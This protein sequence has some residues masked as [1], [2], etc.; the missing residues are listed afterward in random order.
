[1]KLITMKYVLTAALLF[2]TESVAAIAA[3]VISTRTP[4]A[5]APACSSTLALKSKVTPNATV[6]KKTTSG[7]IAA[8][9]P[10]AI[11]YLGKYF[12][13]R[14]NKPAIADAPANQ[15]IRI[16]LISYTVPKCGPKL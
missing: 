9:H 15:R 5:Y 8:A 1:M 7:R 6:V 16:V 4:V 12:G 11:P 13:T 2:Q 14:L 3:E 10:G